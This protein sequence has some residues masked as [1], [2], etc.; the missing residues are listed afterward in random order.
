M[1]EAAQ[2][3]GPFVFG[4]RFLRVQTVALPALQLCVVFRDGMLSI[5]YENLKIPCLKLVHE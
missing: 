3:G 2:M 1:R 4:L 5:I